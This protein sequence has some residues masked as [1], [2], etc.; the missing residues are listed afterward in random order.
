MVVYN[1]SYVDRFTGNVITPADNSFVQYTLTSNIVLQWPELSIN[2]DFFVAN[3]ITIISNTTPNLTVTLPNATNVSTGQSII[4]LNKGTQAFQVLDNTGTE[5]V[6]IATTQAIELMLNDNTTAGGSWDVIT[7]GATT[8]QANASALA[9][10]GLISIAG[11]LNTNWLPK[12]INSN[13]TIQRSDRSYAIIYTGGAAVF[14]LPAPNIAGNGYNVKVINVSTSGGQIT[15]VPS[16]GGI[17]IDGQSSF[18]IYPGQSAEFITDAENSWFVFGYGQET[19][20]SWQINNQAVGGGSDITVT[21]EQAN[22]TIQIFTGVLTAN[23]NVIYP[24]VTNVYIFTNNTTGGSYTLK[25]KTASGTAVEILRNESYS[26]YCDGT[27]FHAFPTTINVGDIIF[28]VGSASEPSITFNDDITTGFYKPFIDTIG[29]TIGG[30]QA[31]AFGT[32]SLELF[33][34]GSASLPALSF[35]ADQTTG[36]Y[37]DADGNLSTSV[38]GSQIFTVTPT[39]ARMNNGNASAPAWSF[40]NAPG[41]GPYLDTSSN[42]SIANGGNQVF[43]VTNTQSVTNDGNASA[44][45]WS[46]R[47]SLSSGV[48]MGG[49]GPTVTYNGANIVS[50]ASTGICNYINGSA[51]SPAWFFYNAQTTGLYLD[52]GNSISLTVGGTKALNVTATKVTFSGSVGN[53]DIVPSSNVGIILNP[54]AGS[55]SS[56]AF[57]DGTGINAIGIV[58]PPSIAASIAFQLPGTVPTT[59]PSTLVCNTTGIMSWSAVNNVQVAVRTNTNLPVSSGGGETFLPFD[60]PTVNV[61]GSFNTTSY[62]FQPTVAGVYSVSVVTNFS[63]TSQVTPTQIALQLYQ[64]ATVVSIAACNPSGFDTLSV[65]LLMQL[66]TSDQVKASIVNNS[67]NS[68][69]TGLSYFN[70][71]LVSR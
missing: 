30:N 21:T 11:K 29:L 39:Q 68:A 26:M 12:Y 38:G 54:Y 61:G 53:L 63:D 40:R 51:S 35:S 34:N 18:S 65:N 7:L 19:F 45:G 28:P 4:F 6:S 56:M 59:N 36:I 32:E 9:G 66:T 17:T 41:V 24:S 33:F 14:T 5:I 13:Y 55:P 62:Y 16:G 71:H 3:W 25:V 60:T 22:K 10:N 42:Y 49:P 27:N 8:S 23:I 57:A 52:T 37:F 31:Y 43:T 67:S 64:N 50:F 70:A 46:F 2:Q 15:V 48:Y 47:G 44:P 69:T 1:N 58:A 20:F